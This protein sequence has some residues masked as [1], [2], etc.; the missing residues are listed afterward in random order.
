[1]IE[2]LH[3]LVLTLVYLT[4]GISLGYACQTML[5]EWGW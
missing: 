5:D 2:T 1:M 3:T 4:T